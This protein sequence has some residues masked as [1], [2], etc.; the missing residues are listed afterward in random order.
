[1][2]KRSV[3][4]LFVLPREDRMSWENGLTPEQAKAAQHSGSNARL[5]AGPGTGKT[6]TL[7]RRI[8]RLLIETGTPPE[9]ILA[10][11]FTKFAAAELRKRVAADVE[12]GQRLPRI[13]T[14][15]SYALR[16][17]LRNESRTK[18]PHPIRIADDWEE[19][20]IVIQELQ[21]M[22]GKSKDDTRKLLAQLS[23]DWQQ[24]AADQEEWER[25][26]P[27]AQFLGAWREHRAIYGYTL[28]AE[29]VYQLKVSLE[30]G[31][32]E[33][34]G[35]P[36]YV[37]VDEFQDLNPCDLAVVHELADLKCEIYG[38]GDDDQSI[39][40]FRYAEPEGI[41]RFPTTFTPSAALELVHCKRC[42]K[43]ILD[44]ALYVARQDPRRI[45]KELSATSAEPGEVKV[46]RFPDEGAEALGIGK[47][48]R[49]LVKRKGLKPEDI[50]ILLR[51]DRNKVFSTPLSAALLSVGVPVSISSNPLEP[52]E[53]DA[54]REFLSL[55]RLIANN[56]DDLA[57]RSI[58]GVRK[59]NVGA[60]TFRAIYE[61]ARRE[62]IRFAAALEMVRRNP[63]LIGAKGKTVQSEVETIR[64][65]VAGSG[66][67]PKD[68]VEEWVSQ[69]AQSEISDPDFRADVL[70][71]FD[72]ADSPRCHSLDE[73]LK[74]ATV[75]LG[76]KEQDV[77][78][79]IASIM[80]MHQAKGLT[81]K[82][83]IV[84]AAE[85]EYIPGRANGRAIDDERRLLYVSLT[86]A[87]H[88]LFVTFANNRRGPQKY[89]GR[90]TGDAARHL[91][92]FLSGGPVKP[93]A[94]D[95]FTSGLR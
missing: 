6:L 86:R 18:L 43:A 24:L 61:I 23:A 2:V 95:A 15:H 16:E 66:P 68:K 55:L 53:T 94:G 48:C 90:T 80:T 39:Y 36:Q 62:G 79:G 14:L 82:A 3:T 7:T 70:K 44:L 46:L 45:E 33:I 4:I 27:D 32:I 73:L 8:V 25:K 71:I 50:L 13:S 52:L 69:L 34:E 77:S 75:T 63:S 84:A 64:K 57:W 88:Y 65:K 30:E 42:D 49:W 60:T 81:A 21:D 5:L 19:E 12:E 87:C 1:L 51:S 78:E 76:E 92:S 28:R 9:S 26:F 91:T 67:P 93:I 89:T 35:P 17:L 59:N 74:S 31:D 20:V 37:L 29:L 56:D 11:T 47:I 54:G 22:L 40:G 41:R 85:D 38:A 83:V 10:F 72:R 58:L